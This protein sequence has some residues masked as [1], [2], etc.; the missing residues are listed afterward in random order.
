LARAERWHISAPIGGGDQGEEEDDALQPFGSRSLAVW[1]AP[2][3]DRLYC[4]SA[5][6]SI[7][8]EPASLT[9]KV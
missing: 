5:L 1:V 6:L 9:L 8:E 2:I 3:G 4:A 7:L